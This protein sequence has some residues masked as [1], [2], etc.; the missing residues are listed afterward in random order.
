MLHCFEKK[1]KKSQILY[2]SNY[3]NFNFWELHYSKF[4]FLIYL[5]D[6]SQCLESHAMV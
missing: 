4:D 1:H 5:S 3:F 6:R 2:D